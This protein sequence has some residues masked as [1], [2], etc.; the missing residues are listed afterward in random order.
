MHQKGNL[1][2][3]YWPVDVMG[4]A[5]KPILGHRRI[6]QA[7][8]HHFAW[9]DATGRLF[10]LCEVS[11]SRVF[12]QFSVFL[13]VELLGTCFAIEAGYEILRKPAKG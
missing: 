7:A 11:L 12:S 1:S 4:I 9:L 5:Y 2:G 3:E 6:T 10:G 13:M 8:V